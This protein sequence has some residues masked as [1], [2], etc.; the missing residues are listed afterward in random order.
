MKNKPGIG[1]RITRPSFALRG[2][3]TG[4]VVYV[5]ENHRWYRIEYKMSDGSIGH[6]CFSFYGPLGIDKEGKK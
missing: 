6:E 3:I 2:L 4:T 1:D 5:N